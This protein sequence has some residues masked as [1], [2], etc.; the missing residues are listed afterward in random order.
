MFGPIQP[1][2][3]RPESPLHVPDGFLDA[4]TSVATGAVAVVGVGVALAK[5]ARRARRP[6]RADGRSRRRLR[7]RGP[8]DQLPGRRR[9]QRAPAR[10]RAWPPCSSGR[11]RAPCAS[12]SC[13]S[14]RAL[15]FADGG[16]TALG[17]NI[18]LMALV[19]AFV[20]LR[21]LPTGAGRP[22]QRIQSVPIA[23][24]VGALVSVPVAATVFTLIFAVGG[25]ADIAIGK[26]F[27]AMVGW[28]A[29]IGIGEAIITALVV[30]PSGLEA[31][32]RPRCTCLVP[33]PG[34]RRRCPREQ[35]SIEPPI[36]RRPAR[37]RRAHRRRRE[38]LRQQP[39]RRARVRRRQDRLPRHG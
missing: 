2:R 23:A 21:R 4:P 25:N 13:S 33:S 24:A 34:T 12:A 37:R 5:V 10:R 39:P 36:L 28:H 11:G 3:P 27:A 18:T 9:H 14:S 15:F 7:L 38:L 16:I 26:V 32:P 31:R 29:V 20:G 22:P 19:G 30:S 35:A 8:D 1:H 6:H 17:T